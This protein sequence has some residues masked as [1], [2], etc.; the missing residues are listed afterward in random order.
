MTWAARE[1]PA[2]NP[3]L[4]GG[5]SAAPPLAGVRVIDASRVLAGPFCTAILADL[6]ADVIRVEHPT[7]QDEVRGWAPE[8]DGMSAA[9]AAVN[10]SKKAVAI[11]LAHAEGVAVF[12]RLLADADVLVENFRPG[13][14]ERMRLGAEALRPIAPR[15]IHCSIR[16]FPQNTSM[17]ALPGYEASMQAISGIMSV[18][19][20]AE[21]EPV[22]CGPSVVDFGTGMVAVIAI[23]SALR[24]RDRT[25]Q[26][27]YVE[28]ALLR[29][30]TAL[31]GLQVAAVSVSGASPSR[32]GSGHDALVPYRIYE[33]A[34]GPILIAAGNDRLWER[35]CG[36]LQFKDPCGDVPFPRLAARVASRNAVDA[37]VSNAVARWARSDLLRVLQTEGIPGAPVNTVGEYVSDP[38][39]VTTGVLQRTSLGSSHEMLVPG[40]LF[41]GLA[42]AKRTPAPRVGEHTDA[43]LNGLGISGDDLDRLRQS[44]AIR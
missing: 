44:G 13:T 29:T 42:T 16:A 19:G 32:R 3:A 26:G 12:K 9:F 25:G 4:D 37:L 17:A 18:T 34:D 24:E 20:E 21:S 2:S 23:L 36:V 38:S 5:S 27:Q 11:D 7:Q 1:Q 35:I 33:C 10:Y 22:R 31:L 15:L 39:L 8:V 43:I 28:P 40:V 41:E 14:L 30:A 6:G